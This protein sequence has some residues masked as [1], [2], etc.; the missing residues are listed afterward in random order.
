MYSIKEL[1]EQLKQLK[2]RL[3][4]QKSNEPEVG[5]ALAAQPPEDEDT[6]IR[7]AREKNQ[8]YGRNPKSI[9]R[10]ARRFPR[11]AAVFEEGK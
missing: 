1:G 3:F 6:E 11:L 8:R 7:A 5:A 4:A 2:E 9:D 10:Y